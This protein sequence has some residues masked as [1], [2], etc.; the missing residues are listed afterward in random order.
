MPKKVALKEAQ[1]GDCTGRMNKQVKEAQAGTLCGN[2]A[3][4]GRV[5]RL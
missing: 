1:T 4:T 3:S 5:G 2:V